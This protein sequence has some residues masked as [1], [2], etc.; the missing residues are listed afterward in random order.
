M[1]DIFSQLGT[2][3]SETWTDVAD[4]VIAIF[5]QA[6]FAILILLLGLLI[7]LIIRF[8]LMKIFIFFAVDKLAAK[9]Q[10]TAILKSVGLKK[11]VSQILGSLFFWLI[12]LFTLIFA[13]QILELEQVTKALGVIASF[14]PKVIAAFMIVV[15]GMLLAKFLQTLVMQTIGRT[16]LGY[17][18]TMGKVVNAIVIIFSIIAALEQLEIDLSLVTTNFI[19]LFSVMLFVAGIGGVVG[20][21]KLLE[22]FFAMNALR[23][24]LAIGDSVRILTYH[25]TI[26]GMTKTSVIINHE[27]Q[28]V[29]LPATLF[30][31]ESYTRTRSN[32]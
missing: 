14:V 4:G 20:G 28:E 16:E 19:V 29:L 26:T 10:L 32:D 22:N 1:E 9:T 7:A 24:Q 17:E 27:H 3:F 31:S 23:S 25:G 30:L 8:A 18:R 2:L 21:R 13:S 6:A 12:V 5:P 15:F 11:S